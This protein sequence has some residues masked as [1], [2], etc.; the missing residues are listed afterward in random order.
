MHITYYRN[1]QII[2][3]HGILYLVSGD[4]RESGP[5]ARGAEVPE[6]EL[7]R[8][9]AGAHTLEVVTIGHQPAPSEDAVTRINRKTATL[10][11]WCCCGA[12]RCHAEYQLRT[13]HLLSIE[14]ILGTAALIIMANML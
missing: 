8:G 7:A 3:Y 13:P 5:Y 9:A 6:A 4:R 12:P 10:Q 14:C 2:K 1:N 11:D